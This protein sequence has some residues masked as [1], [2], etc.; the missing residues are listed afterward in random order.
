MVCEWDKEIH[1][2]GLPLLRDSRPVQRAE[3]LHQ[4]RYMGEGEGEGKGG[5]GGMKVYCFR[6]G[7]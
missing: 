6:G 7:M 2:L 1:K 4:V 3:D 5:G